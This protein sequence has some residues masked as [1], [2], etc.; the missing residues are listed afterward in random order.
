MGGAQLTRNLP[1]ARLSAGSTTIP[2]NL[3]TDV[4][5]ND[6][7][8]TGLGAVVE[9]QLGS[10]ALE[11]F[12]GASAD[13]LDSPF[14]AASWPTH[15]AAALRLR[16]PLGGGWTVSSEAQLGQQ[17]TALGS[18]EWAATNAT[19]DARRS[20]R[21]ALSAGVGDGH[22][23]AAAS[24]VATRPS[25]DFKGS[26]SVANPQF[27][28]TDLPPAL[29]VEPD[30]ENFSLVLRPMR[31]L[32]FTL[33][34]ENFLTPAS[35]LQAPA[36][37]AP[38]RSTVNQVGLDARLGDLTV[39]AT[40]FQSRYNGS[41]DAALSIAASRDF[42]PGMHLQTT[43][44]A[45]RPE[46]RGLEPADPGTRTLVVNV[47]R[48]LTPRWGVSTAFNRSNGQQSV[49]FGGSFLS[50]AV[51]FSAE[52]QTFYVPANIADP[53]EQVLLLSADLHLRGG[54]TL[55][56]ENFVA[57]NGRLMYTT[58][59][60]GTAAVHRPVPAASG[61]NSMGG[62][63][64]DGR[65]LDPQGRPVGGAALLIDQRP[66]YSNSSGYFLIREKKS[67]LHL[68]AV[69]G[70]QFLDG[71]AYRVVSAP[72]QTRSIQAG[73]SQPGIVIVVERIAPSGTAV[74]P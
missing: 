23:Y 4:F 43:Y 39:S 17:R 53:F 30:R 67:H 33:T 59:A 60:N 62:M 71:Y 42:G 48:D 24:L 61:R 5:D 63:V 29:T 73:E 1:L 36:S 66:I 11:A 13:V 26:Y 69:L 68:L 52:Y 12:G 50:N 44:L 22:G 51:T 46:A 72:A 49:G 56:A 28:R 32:S 38:V 7:F 41:G 74:Q 58:A 18:I 47:Q 31:R 21:L 45:S 54:T 2:F 65:V 34:R 27:R 3:P 25:F 70:G 20:L 16:A 64:L 35:T 6:H 14:F 40:G 37:A 19:H 9:T 15:A 55:H 57:P 8:L 10:L